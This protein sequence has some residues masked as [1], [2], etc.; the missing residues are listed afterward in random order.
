MQYIWIAFILPVLPYFPFYSVREDQT[1]NS[2]FDYNEV[3][4]FLRPFYV[5]LDEVQEYC[6][7]N[8]NKIEIKAKIQTAKVL[9]AVLQSSPN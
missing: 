5:L 4:F 1:P 7:F 8:K 6:N 2:E 3:S 9:R